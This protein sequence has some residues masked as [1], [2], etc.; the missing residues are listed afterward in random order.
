MSERDKE[1]IYKLKH[2]LT[3]EQVQ[4]EYGH[5]MNQRPQIFD[6]TD[7]SDDDELTDAEIDNLLDGQ[8]DDTVDETEEQY[9]NDY[10]PV[11]YSDK[12]DVILPDDF[13]TWSNFAKT[14]WLKKQGCI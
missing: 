10:K 6:V 13:E 12:Y 5:L 1:I 7:V 2:P 9:V 8:E 3:P 14:A 4:E 11:N